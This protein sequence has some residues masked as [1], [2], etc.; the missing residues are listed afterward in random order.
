MSCNI[1]STVKQLRKIQHIKWIS[2]QGYIGKILAQRFHRSV[3][4]LEKDDSRAQSS[5]CRSA[6][7]GVTS[8][9]FTLLNNEESFTHFDQVLQETIDSQI[10]SPSSSSWEQLQRNFS[11]LDTKRAECG[12]VCMIGLHCCGDLTPTMLRCFARFTALI[13]LLRH[14]IINDLIDFLG[15][16]L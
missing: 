1:F 3:I 7:A 11:G 6:T 2:S 15:V 12:R 14:Q 13:M 8:L 16:T 4:G 9:A 5:V 10:K